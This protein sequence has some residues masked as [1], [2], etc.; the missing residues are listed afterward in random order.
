MA[1]PLRPDDPVALGPY[2]LRE[3]LGAGGMGTVFLAE[4]ADGRRVAVK[5]INPGVAGDAEFQTRFRREVAAARRVRRF[6]TAPVL[7]A[8]VDAP[9]LYVVTEYVAGPT[10]QEAVRRD[11]PMRGADLE[12]LAVGIATALSAIHD[13]GLVHRDLKPANVLLSAVGPRVIDFGIARAVDVEGVTA[14]GQLLGTPA[15][16]APEQITGEPVSPA[17]DVFAWACV[18]AYA[19][20]GRAPFAGATLP[21]ILYRVAHDPP[22]L[23]GLDPALLPLVTAALNKSSTTRPTVPDLLTHLTGRPDPTTPTSPPPNPP[24]HDPPT[25]TTDGRAASPVP[26][27]VGSPYETPAAPTTDGRAAGPTSHPDG[28][29]HHDAPAAPT[30]EGWAASPA[31]PSGG[32]PHHG[33]PATPTTDGRVAGPTSPSGERPRYDASAA[34][35]GDGW[36]AGPSA[37]A[38]GPARY[39]GP[40]SAA[41]GRVVGPAAPSGGLPRHDV[42]AGASGA[43]DSGAR[44]GYEA[45]GAPGG[46]WAAG[47][48]AGYGAGREVPPPSPGPGA[49]V[50]GAAQG[51]QGAWGGGVGPGAGGAPRGGQAGSG[52][53]RRARVVLAVV[54]ALVVGAGVLVGL[55][56]VFGD[57][58]DS[59][60]SSTVGDDPDRALEEVPQTFVGTWEGHVEQGGANVNSFTV[61][62]RIEGGARG[63]H[64]GGTSYPELSCTGAL[65]LVHA[66]SR[67]LSVTETITAGGC[68]PT[69]DVTVTYEDDVLRFE[70]T[71]S[72]GNHGNGELTRVGNR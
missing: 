71:D 34:S 14:T 54:L 38:G 37:P 53:R 30:A 22:D 43:E 57:N 52:G 19:G 21:Q 68:A 32:P 1:E 11:G 62:V 25:P 28:R 6:C 29:P 46:G 13:A 5:V 16:M 31:T 48:G 66:T 51:T 2:R 50:P 60:P 24:H 67:F 45:E 15:Y 63:S 33:T 20:T 36:A 65:T 17:T 42:T 47:H 9:P 59:S 64:V 10:L 49:T 35:G 27:P 69:S 44:R 40:E 41:G 8:S 56:G 7:D 23:T 61:T 39:D 18:V 3:R 4:G 55:S 12:G 26:P 70:F 72:R 58:P